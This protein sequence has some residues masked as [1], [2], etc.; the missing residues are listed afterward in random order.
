MH[1]LSISDPPTRYRRFGV[2]LDLIP[3]EGIDPRIIVGCFTLQPLRVARF[4]L[5]RE[6]LNRAEIDRV[7]EVAERYPISFDE[8]PEIT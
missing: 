4:A 1:I 3:H 5:R 7:I 2:H 8:L 6:G